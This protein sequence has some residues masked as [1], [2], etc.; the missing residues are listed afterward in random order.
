[1]TSRLVLGTGSLAGALVGELSGR[2]G[3]LSVVS[4]DE[5]A[6]RT[7]REEE[8][9]RRSATPRKR[10]HYVSA[11]GPT[12]SPSRRRTRGPTWLRRG[13]SGRCS[14]ARSSSPTSASGPPTTR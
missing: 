8:S 10:R 4:A 6:V 13:P 2:E 9:R 11:I 7:L 5:N 1:M 3:R 14:R 12:P